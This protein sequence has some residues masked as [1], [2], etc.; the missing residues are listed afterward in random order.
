MDT[1]NSIE[2]SLANGSSSDAIQQLLAWT[3]VPSLVFFA[4]FLVYFA[5]H[6]IHR[7]RVDKAIF[8]IRD[9]LR[10]IKARQTINANPSTP[11]VAEENPPEQQ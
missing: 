10:E 11:P 9:N 3:V 7:H 5:F 6:I 8:E 2:Q 1:L 4:A